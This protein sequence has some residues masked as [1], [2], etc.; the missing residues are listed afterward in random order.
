MTC[1]RQLAVILVLCLLAGAAVTALA[2]SASQSAGKKPVTLPAPD[3]QPR[4][5]NQN[6]PVSDQHD[7]Y[8]FSVISRLVVLHATVLDKDKHLVTDLSKSDFKVFEDNVEQRIRDFKREDIPVSVGI[9]VDN[10]GSMREKRSRVNA[11]ALT[12]VRTSNPQDEV[13]IVNFNDEAF[14]DQDF[15]DSLDMLKE[16]LEKID[17]RG[18][19]AFYDALQM[20]IDHL[21]E[22]AK[23][24]KKVLLVVTDGED[25]ASR[26]GLEQ[27]V[28]YVHES[29]A[30][31]YTVG[32]LGEENPR[33][34]KR[35]K[36][37]LEAVSEASG[38]AAFFPKDTNEVEGIATRIAHDIRNQYVLTYTPSNPAE[39][40]RYRAVSVKAES[41]AHGKL[42]V[43]T[44][45]GYYAGKEPS[46]APASTSGG[47]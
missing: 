25:N 17:A 31:I 9:L 21:K 6:Q 15:T 29:E 26:M 36:K 40:G 47:Y 13:F 18:G 30:V 28:K 16:G 7:T 27:L 3:V 8:K 42:F 20:S 38:G 19:T 24:S 37:A 2:Q 12:F 11:A 32:L 41:K 33:A 5:Q 14:L 45:T 39:D 46:T 44:R 1:S 34:A 23:R 22:G 4:P 35:A 10:S 43:R